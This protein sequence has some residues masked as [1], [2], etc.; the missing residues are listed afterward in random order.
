MNQLNYVW[1]VTKEAFT[2]FGRDNCFR[3]CAA[4]SF[5]TLFSIAPIV[6]M[7]L[8]VAG[9]FIDNTSLRDEI[10]RQFQTLIGEKGAH[11]VQVLI[12]V[13]QRQE[14]NTFRLILG[15]VVLVISATT[16]F[17]QMQ[18][19]LD[20]IF[21]VRPVRGKG[22]IKKLLLDR[23]ISLGMILSLGLITIVSLVL[24]SLVVSVIHNLL[25]SYKEMSVILV[26]IGQNAIIFFIMGGMLFAIF[27]FLPDVTIPGK[28][29]L[30]SA[31]I[32]TLLLLLGKFGIGW[33]ISNSNFSQLGGASSSIIILMLWVY[34]SSMI[35][36]FGA[37]LVKAQAVVKDIELPA[38]HYGVK[39]KYVEKKEDE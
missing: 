28:L 29:V 37:E 9:L 33:Y 21:H 35:L 36:M 8:F 22:V 25:D 31:V 20:E 11:G 34:Y 13:L 30:R 24:D 19:A 3:F 38:Q 6:L 5:Y 16:I 17:I 4:L 23:V 7:S 39:V 10:I 15:I 27:K 1:Q 12:E 2:N 32:T 14:Q 18:G 26:D